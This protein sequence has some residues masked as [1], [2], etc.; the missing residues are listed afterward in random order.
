MLCRRIQIAAFTSRALELKFCR[1]AF[2][3]SDVSCRCWSVSLHIFE[4]NEEKLIFS[5]VLR[6]A[7]KYV[8]TEII[9][10]I[11][12]E[13]RCRW[14]KMVLWECNLVRSVFLLFVFFVFLLLTLMIA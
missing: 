5:K 9:Q 11:K 1:H 6:I 14:R 4:Y 10:D 2:A 7:D 3:K 13:N 12:C 8:D